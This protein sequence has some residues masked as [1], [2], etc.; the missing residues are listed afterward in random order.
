MRERIAARG[1]A[2]EYFGTIRSAAGVRRTHAGGVSSHFADADR[3]RAV[4]DGVP[5]YVAASLILG[6]LAAGPD[7]PPVASA[8]TDRVRAESPELRTLIDTTAARSPTVRQLMARLGCTDAIVYVEIV[9]SPQI[10]TGRTLLVAT[11]GGARFLRIGINVGLSDTDR[12][13]L[14]GHELQHAI[15]IAEHGEVRDTAAVRRLFERIGRARGGDRY[16]T[17]AARDVE[18]AVRAELRTKIG[19]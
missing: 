5:A 15:E 8:V 12:S 17:E 1:A 11:A 6:L 10:P 3:R 13:A 9:S 16:E 19:G 4:S 14:L 7:R 18:W 2:R